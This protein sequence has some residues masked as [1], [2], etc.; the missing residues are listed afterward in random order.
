MFEERGRV[1]Y[2]FTYLS[3]KKLLTSACAP[4][5]QS[6]RHFIGSS[7]AV[8][9]VSPLIPVKT[10][11]KSHPLRYLPLG[12]LTALFKF[13]RNGYLS[14]FRW[15]TS[16]QKATIFTDLERVSYNIIHLFGLEINIGN[17]NFLIHRADES[18]DA[19]STRSRSYL[20]DPSGT[21][22][23]PLNYVH[24]PTTET[25]TTSESQGKSTFN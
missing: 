19:N 17:T 5:I 20:P 10:D 22:Q 23:Y 4:L 16:S 24:L 25:K 8:V 2:L 18:R 14:H 6:T 1:M 9:Y 15:S 11:W 3:Y 21:L 7:F 13:M 12:R